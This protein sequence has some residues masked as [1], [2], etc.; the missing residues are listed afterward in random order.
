MLIAHKTQSCRT[1]VNRIVNSV[2]LWL[3][4]SKLFTFL[5]VE[6]DNS[7]N[8]VTTHKVETIDY[9]F[10]NCSTTSRFGCICSTMVHI[11]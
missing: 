3:S 10:D 1:V 9:S 2:T 11:H 6:L 4:L 5:V 7:D 8:L